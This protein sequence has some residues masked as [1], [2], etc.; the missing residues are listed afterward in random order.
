LK[1]NPICFHPQRDGFHKY[2]DIIKMH[3]RVC[4]LKLCLYLLKYSRWKMQRNG[5]I[6]ILTWILTTLR[7]Y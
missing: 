5:L 4:F 6:E 3:L 1:N 2:N 7:S